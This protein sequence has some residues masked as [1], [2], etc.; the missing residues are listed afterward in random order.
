[1]LPV[2]V[3]GDTLQTAVEKRLAHHSQ[4]VAKRIEQFYPILFR[5][6]FVVL[7]IRFPGK[8]VV[9]DLIEAACR[10]LFRNEGLEFMLTVGRGL[11]R[12]IGF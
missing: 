6:S 2:P 9:H 5:E 12:Q 7:V 11:I 4:V 1:M 3:I 8:R 10:K